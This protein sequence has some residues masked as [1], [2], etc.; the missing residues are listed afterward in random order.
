MFNKIDKEYLCQTIKGLMA[1]DSPSGY[2]AKAIEYIGERAKELGHEF[3]ITNKGCGVILV[4]GK[5]S[6][7]KVGLAAHTDTLGL[8]VRSI[9]G[10]GTLNFTKIGG[11]QLPT[12]DG[13]YCRIYTRDG[14]VYTGTVLSKSPSS[15]V[16]PDAATR[17]RSEENM[18]IRIDEQVRSA[19][20]V[21]K[22]GIAVGDIIAYDPKT[23]ITASG[24]VKSRF[25][26]DKASV[27]CILAA[28]KA[29]KDGGLKPRYDTEVYLTVYEEVGHGGAP[30]GEG[31][32]EML[33]VDMGCIG[34]DLSCTEYDVSI[35]PKD[36]G[37]PYDYEMVSRLKDYAEA[38][39]LDYVLDIYPFYGSDVGAMY[40][41]GHDVRGALIG[42][43]I[44]ASHGMERTHINALMQTIKLIM[45]Y[46]EAK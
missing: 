43:G 37:G 40:R 4:K 2:C 36:G 29:M 10:D 46:L 16:Y 39:K 31:L 23:E 11:P 13:E 35:C 6:G 3:K 30:M 1:I 41:A 26:D 27:A 5:E 45:L 20:D 22:L 33:A 24:F 17:A 44:H 7:K 28:L 32:S 14:K 19:E 21:K 12:I 34:L 15:H 8:M 38:N 18:Y 42:P 9:G 25:L